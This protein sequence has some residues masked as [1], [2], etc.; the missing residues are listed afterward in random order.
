MVQGGAEKQGDALD[1]LDALAELD[2]HPPYQA[3]ASTPPR[4]SSRPMTTSPHISP[5]GS[6][7]SLRSTPSPRGSFR[8]SLKGTYQRSTSSLSRALQ[9]EAA[10]GDEEDDGPT[11]SRHQAGFNSPARHTSGGHDSLSRTSS[12][13]FSV[14]G[15]PSPLDPKQVEDPASPAPAARG[16]PLRLLARAPCNQSRPGDE[17]ALFQE[18]EASSGALPTWQR[19]ESPAPDDAST[20]SGRSSFLSDR[21]LPRSSSLR[22]KNLRKDIALEAHRI[23][24]RAS[25]EELRRNA[26]AA[27]RL[28][29]ELDPAQEHAPIA[30]TSEATGRA[31]KSPIQEA[32]LSVPDDVGS[33]RSYESYDAL[34]FTSVADSPRL[35]SARAPGSDSTYSLASGQSPSMRADGFATDKTRRSRPREAREWTQACWLWCDDPLPASKLASSGLFTKTPGAIVSSAFKRKSNKRESAQHFS[36][37]EAMLFDKPNAST[38]TTKERD[39]K[40]KVEPQLPPPERRVVSSNGP[41][42][43]AISG[44]W[45]RVSAVLRDDGYLRIYSDNDNRILRTVQLA[46][47]NQCGIR[48]VDHSLFGRP[49]CLCIDVGA[50]AAIT[51]ASVSASSLSLPLPLKHPAPLYL[52]LPS[53]VTAHV[54]FVMTRCFASPDESTFDAQSLQ[55]LR[56]RSGDLQL[57]KDEEVEEEG[58]QPKEIDALSGE[59]K[60]GYRI[61]RSL[62][63]CVNECRGLNEATSDSLRSASK[64]SSEQPAVALT[65]T[66]AVGHEGPSMYCEIDIEG[67]IVGQTSTRGGPAPFWSD[68]FAW[69]DLPPMLEPARI[70]VLQTSKTRARLVGVVEVRLPDLPR[71][72]LNEAWLPVR[73][74]SAEP[75]AEDVL[76]ELSVSTRVSEEVVLPLFCYDRILQML[77]ADENAE[78]VTAIAAALPHELEETTR[79]LL[80]I[81]ASQS[82]LVDRIDRLTRLEVEAGLRQNRSAALLFRGNTILTKSIELYLRLVG[83]EYLDAS[84]GEVVRRICEDKVEIEI[85]PLKVRPSVKEKETLRNMRE[86]QEWTKRLWDAISR[87][88]GKCPRDLRLIFSRIQAAVVSRYEQVDDNKNTQYTCISAF[89]FLRFF[90]PAILNPRLFLLVPSAPDPRA[91]RT[92]TLVA[93]SLQGLANFSSFGQK[94]PWMQPMNRVVE[95]CSQGLVDFLQ[96]VSTPVDSVAHRQEWTSPNAAAYVI[97]NRLRNALPPLVRE[98][99]PSLPHLIDLPKELGALARRLSRLNP[100]A[101]GDAL[102]SSSS[103][104]SSAEKL[105]TASQAFQE[106]IKA[107]VEVEQ[108]AHRRAGA[109]AGPPVPS[110]LPE[111]VRRGDLRPRGLSSRSAIADGDVDPLRSRRSLRMPR[112]VSNLRAA[113]SDQEE[114]ESDESTGV[115]RRQTCTTL[116][117][118]HRS[119]TISGP[120][121]ET[122]TLGNGTFPGRSFTNED[123]SAL[124]TLGSVDDIFAT[125]AQ[126]RTDFRAGIENLGRD[127]V[128]GSQRAAPPPREV[129]HGGSA[130]L[131]FRPATASVQITQET[132]TTET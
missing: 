6:E 74:P 115:R 31:N 35:G 15:P 57:F 84:I 104:P 32:I 3:A 69:K 20:R 33:F 39:K 88:R 37:A 56:R 116:R 5:R 80:H 108:E 113:E 73:A 49:N 68:T 13:F 105:P 47:Q 10:K 36:P 82:L 72:K 23:R 64:S 43:P 98:A 99:V 112:T 95:D 53:L 103:A 93:K 125:D 87:A 101:A 18:L 48:L 83:A 22:V 85:D 81:F 77:R 8:S 109:L 70:R 65:S 120:G 61:V 122:V 40:S 60:D 25:L 124:A 123:L 97:P 111:D 46:H 67:G 11:P 118:T 71:Q 59:Q 26:E 24:E 96:H 92:L 51:P 52:C 41:A 2:M 42:S 19:A 44:Q 17:L 79:T 132:V 76:A 55:R 94:E 75:S 12:E 100:T 106:L 54:W 1:L 117:Q 63:L 121:A 30:T 90:V 50:S 107:S 62:Q 28:S 78:L 29:S 114:P 45:K 4:T 89:I 27:H 102:R 131:P 58:R 86:L 110:T 16:S 127:R 126:S 9:R 66:L 128:V 7:H 129:A 38:A 34:S 130:L 21:G 91:Q 14:A 119:F